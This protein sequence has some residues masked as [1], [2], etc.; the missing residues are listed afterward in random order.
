MPVTKITNFN[1]RG[2]SGDRHQ[3]TNLDTWTDPLL[4]GTVLINKKK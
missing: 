1:P 4:L 3:I 2:N